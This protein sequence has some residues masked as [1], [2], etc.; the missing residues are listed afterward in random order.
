MTFSYTVGSDDLQLDQDGVYP[1]LLNVNGTVDGDA[2]RVGELP[3]FLV[4]QPVVPTARTAV[5]W[6]WPLAERTHRGPTGEF[7][8][9]DL[10]RSDLQ[11][12]PPR[13]GAGRRSSVCP[14]AP[15][16]AATERCPRCRWSS[17]STPRWSRSCSSWRPGPT[18][19]A[20]WR[21]PVSGTDAAA[22]YLDRLTAVAAVHPVVALPYG[23]VDVDSLTAAGLARR[24]DP[25]PSGDPGRDGAGPAPRG[26]GRRRRDLPPGRADHRR[27]P[28]RRTPDTG[29]GAGSSPT[30]STSSA[31]HRRRVGRRRHPAPRHAGHPAGRRRRSRRPRQRRAHRRRRRPWDCPATSPPR[32]RRWPRRPDRSTRWSPTRRSARIV[33]AAEQTPGGARMA[34]QRYLAELA[35]LTLQAPPGT[36]QTRA[37]R[38][39]PRRAGRA[40][41]RRR[42]DGRRVPGLPW[43]RPTGPDELFAGP[44]APAG[45]L[46]AGGASRR[47]R[48]GRAGRRG[49]GGRRAGRPR[50]RRGRGRRRR[51]AGLR[52]RDRARDLGRPGAATPRA[53]VPR[54]TACW[55]RW[56]GCAGG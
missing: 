21:T 31:A 8:D 2:R 56:T 16:P 12:R 9:D 11:R 18:P 22:T 17:P 51:D 3:T 27:H 52:R 33:G 7:I 41:G 54:R 30:R 40:R 38:T 36:E 10:S 42:D 46:A 4:Q 43:L 29:A 1:V 39:A 6:L 24:R 34:E 48:P 47:A 35:V 28:R 50:R 44:S 53:S 13:P 14:A 32:T 26:A 23:D 55:P 5:G 37:G 25:Q 20:G 19:S 45:E 15:R 49:R